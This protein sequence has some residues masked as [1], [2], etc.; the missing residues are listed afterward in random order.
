MN[1]SNLPT[2]DK[3]RAAARSVEPRH[4]FSDGLWNQ[5]ADTPQH[6][7][8]YAAFK[9]PFTRPAWSIGTA[10][11]IVGLIVFAIGPQNVLA[12]F[13]N[14]I[15]YLPGIGFVQNDS[16]TLYLPKPVSVSKDG[17][18]LTVEQVVADADTT[19]VAYHIDG[20]KDSQASVCFYDNNLVKTS[21]GKML[22]PTGGGVTGNQ[23][24][25][26]YMPLPAGSDKMTLL[27]S[28]NVADPA[29]TA[30]AEWSIDLT[31]G[32]MPAN[33]TVMPVVEE[34]RPADAAAD[35][36]TPSTPLSAGIP[37]DQLADFSFVIDKSVELSDGYMITGHIQMKD[38][39]MENLSVF[40]ETL[41][42]NGADGQSYPIE[43]SDEGTK[44]NELAYKITGKPLKIPLTIAIQ[45]A[46]VIANM[47]DGPSFSFDAG[48]D[49]R[50]GQ[51][52]DVD[53]DLDVLG[54]KVS[55]GKAT[56]IHNDNGA[57]QADKAD[58][59]A[60]EINTDPAIAH[61]NF[62]C[63][64]NTAGGMGWSESSK[65]AHSGNA[66]ELRTFFEKGIPS[67]TVSFKVTMLELE[68]TGSWETTWQVPE[69]A[70]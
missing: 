55:I 49:P 31:L 4:E 7:P 37:A 22:H 6:T 66:W 5:I 21:D 35:Q 68:L 64:T 12:A 47:D 65:Q 16:S 26:E 53:Q 52:W 1:S 18:T 44:D 13:T 45:T 33:V 30:P 38:L 11:V 34:T 32:A 67:G 43:P 63:T 70:K 51:S 36:T 19:T 48:S 23:A 69:A 54:K 39:S 46:Q 17:I 3:I 60:F 41:T 24:R 20:M 59:F 2:E 10:V 28:M 29:C 14:L 25:I 62:F 57:N 27:V 56:A 61:I 15:G 8:W 58:G 42:A 9:K 40:P 50:V